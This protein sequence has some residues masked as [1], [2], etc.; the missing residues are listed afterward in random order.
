VK[1]NDERALAVSSLRGGAL[2]ATDFDP[3]EWEIM[4]PSF[5]QRRPRGSF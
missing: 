2:S 4:Y 3:S 5:C 1:I